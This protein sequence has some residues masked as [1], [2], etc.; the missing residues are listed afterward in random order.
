[1]EKKT[2]IKGRTGSTECYERLCVLSDS[3]GM[4]A[5]DWQTRQQ[6]V[7]EIM[8][9]DSTDIVPQDLQNHHLPFLNTHNSNCTIQQTT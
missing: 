7:D 1:M 3:G 2:N 5:A 6:Q 8:S 4:L 9:R